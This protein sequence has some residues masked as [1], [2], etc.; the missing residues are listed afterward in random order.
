MPNITE[1]IRE[2]VVNKL[3]EFCEE[4]EIAPE[5]IPVYA[6]DAALRAFEDRNEISKF[7][8]MFKGLI[9]QIEERSM[10]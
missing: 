5:L 6:L 9:T 7:L 10:S 8:Q 2:E 3:I 1:E 4:N